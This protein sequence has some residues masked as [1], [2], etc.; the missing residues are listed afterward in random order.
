MNFFQVYH[1]CSLASLQEIKKHGQ[2][3]V[4]RG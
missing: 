1:S 3:R 2:S 4:E